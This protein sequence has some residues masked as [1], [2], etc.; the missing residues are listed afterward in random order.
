MRTKEEGVEHAMA[1]WEMRLNCAESVFRGF[2]HA[3]GLAPT[4]QAKCMAT[5][6]GGG[7]G[8]SEDVCGALSGGIL[9]L[10]LALGRAEPDQ[11]KLRCYD[12][13]K[14]LHSSFTRLFGSSS[15]RELNRGDFQSREHRVRCG[16]FVRESC[17]LAIEIVRE[18][19]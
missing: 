19:E 15:C 4:D 12:A 11:D 2:C 13:A 9:G 1:C 7:I 3:Q 6:F 18:E 8:R 17:R 14:R 5:P 10:G 16:G